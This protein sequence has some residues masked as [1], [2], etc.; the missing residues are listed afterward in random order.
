VAVNP[1]VPAT[2][3]ADTL[4]LVT[5]YIPPKRMIPLVDKAT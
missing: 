3:N 2:A 4:K 1:G 5:R